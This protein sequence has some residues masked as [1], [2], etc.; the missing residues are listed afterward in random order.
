[1]RDRTCLCELINS[2]MV[3]G[4]NPPVQCPEH[5]ANYSIPPEGVAAPFHKWQFWFSKHALCWG[6]RKSGTTY[7]EIG[8]LW[9]FVIVWGIGHFVVLPL[10]P[11]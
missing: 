3:D 9:V 6:D 1:M 11:K 7:H 4:K 5:P 8:Y 10:L 2:G